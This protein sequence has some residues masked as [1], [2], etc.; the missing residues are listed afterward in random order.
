MIQQSPCFTVLAM[1]A[2]LKL[3]TTLLRVYAACNQPT[4]LVLD[5]FAT[6]SRIYLS[7]LIKIIRQDCRSFL[8]LVRF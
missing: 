8:D 2:D 7:T 1:T 3:K 5:R 6:V 4:T